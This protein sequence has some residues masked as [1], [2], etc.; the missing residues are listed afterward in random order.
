MPRN[1][2]IQVGPLVFASKKDTKAYFRLMVARYVDGQ[3]MELEDDAV[4]RDLICLHPE[5][6][7]KIGVGISHF[8]VATDN[9][10][11][12][13][14]H[15]VIVRVN[16]ESTDFSY[17]TCIDGTNMRQ[18]VFAALRFAV[19]HQVSDFKR[20]SF[21]APDKPRCPFHNCELTEDE[22]HVDHAAPLTFYAIV[23]EFLRSRG[24]TLDAL[25]LIDNADNQ[26]VRELRD[27]EIVKNWQDFHRSNARLR[28]TSSRANLSEA[29]KRPNDAGQV[30][31]ASVA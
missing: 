30:G 7:Q 15:F 4:L 17:H 26:L 10:W 5:R 31:R 25:L 23:G 9:E 22:A 3:R 8:T 21:A 13:T 14:R 6:E 16:G 24:L 28:L 11:G 18:D 2:P 12:R 29:R 1:I 27:P 19:R 20:D